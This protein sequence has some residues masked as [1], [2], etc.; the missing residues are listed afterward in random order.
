M[1]VAG[2]NAII[3]VAKTKTLFT[4]KHLRGWLP[5]IPVPEAFR[6]AASADEA[7]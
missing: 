4:N 5:S 7:R 3:V 6:F 1:A 2:G